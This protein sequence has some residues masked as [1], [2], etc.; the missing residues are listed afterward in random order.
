MLTPAFSRSLV[1]AVSG[2][3]SRGT[4]L[5]VL[6][7]FLVGWPASHFPG[8]QN[9]NQGI[10]Q[11]SL[12]THNSPQRNDS[13]GTL[14][15]LKTLKPAHQPKSLNGGVRLPPGPGAGSPGWGSWDAGGTRTDESAHEKPEKPAWGPLPW[16]S[17]R[18]LALQQLPPH[19]ERRRVSRRH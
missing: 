9:T 7:E 2:L 17:L 3:G 19:P 15:G 11:T 18:Y 8:G 13:Q 6:E 1:G 14:I 12:Q 16:L 10:T 5:Y 4:G